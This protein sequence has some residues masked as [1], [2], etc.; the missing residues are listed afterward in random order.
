[1][2]SLIYVYCLRLKYKYYVCLVT[3]DEEMN[4]QPWW[5]YSV[6]VFQITQSNGDLPTHNLS[7]KFP[8]IF[9]FPQNDFLIFYDTVDLILGSVRSGAR[10]R[11]SVLTTPVE[12]M[13]GKTSYNDEI[14][15]KG[16]FFGFADFHRRLYCISVSGTRFRDGAEKTPRFVHKK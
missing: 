15:F 2:L 12:T 1:M 5:K 4:G 13:A 10:E 16:N 7:F 9:S 14:V 11:V 6:N 3:Y 8:W